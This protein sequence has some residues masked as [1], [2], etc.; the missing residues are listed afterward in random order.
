M[1]SSGSKE[2]EKSLERFIRVLPQFNEQY[3]LKQYGLKRHA[4]ISCNRVHC[5]QLFL[6]SWTCSQVL[7]IS[8]LTMFSAGLHAFNLHEVK[9]C[10]PDA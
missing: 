4:Q 5:C 1:A 10:K 3:Q 6:F 9:E 2:R 8:S 7:F